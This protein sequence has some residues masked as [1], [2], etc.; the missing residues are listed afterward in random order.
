MQRYY[1]LNG[2]TLVMLIG[3]AIWQNIQSYSE[4][5]LGSWKAF[6]RTEL[7]NEPIEDKH[8]EMQECQT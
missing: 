1:S 5:T 7:M 8:E 6:Q 4:T 2:L 3:R